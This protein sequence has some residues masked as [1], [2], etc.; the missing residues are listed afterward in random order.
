[1][2]VAAPVA[3][4]VVVFGQRVGSGPGAPRI[5]FHDVTCLFYGTDAPGCAPLLRCGAVH[6]YGRIYITFIF[7]IQPGGEQGIARHDNDGMALRR[8]P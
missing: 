5:F 7:Q 2:T 6:A 8:C 3:V 1:M 4:H